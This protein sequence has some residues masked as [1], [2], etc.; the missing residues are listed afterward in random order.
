MIGVS[1]AIF[2]SHD[3]FFQ[4]ASVGKAHIDKLCARMIPGVK[5][6]LQQRLFLL[7]AIRLLFTASRSLCLIILIFSPP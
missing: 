2:T 3:G 4:L 7:T 1:A 5:K 6:N